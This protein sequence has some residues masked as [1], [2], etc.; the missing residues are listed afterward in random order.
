V[1]TLQN[2]E[3]PHDHYLSRLEAVLS[4]IRCAV[5]KGHGKYGDSCLQRGG[6]GLYMMLARKWDRLER[7]ASLTGYDLLSMIE[8]DVVAN[9][10]DGVADDV[11]DLCAYLVIALSENQ[12]GASPVQLDLFD[13]ETEGWPPSV[14]QPRVTEQGEGE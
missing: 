1:T 13:S 4:A 11:L 7:D 12:V 2:P 14:L 6:V 3:T 5:I 8:R 9:V 10:V